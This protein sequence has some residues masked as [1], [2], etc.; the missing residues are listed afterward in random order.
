MN[1][2]QTRVINR[3]AL[4]SGWNIGSVTPAATFEDLQIDSLDILES[5]LFIEEEFSIEISDARAE[6]FNSVQD[7]IDYV[8]EVTK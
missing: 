6:L 7:V 4:Q 3:I 2:V 1:S 8:T 5:V